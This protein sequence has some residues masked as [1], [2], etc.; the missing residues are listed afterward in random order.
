MTADA[1]HHVAG[2]D[3]T[4]PLPST[5]YSAPKTKP[6]GLDWSKHTAP[7]P[8]PAPVVE[9]PEATVTEIRRRIKAPRPTAGRKCQC[10]R[11]IN[12]KSDYCR[13]CNGRRAAANRTT[14]TTRTS[15]VDVTVAQEE[16]TA[17]A[18]VPEIAAAHDWPITSVRRQLERAG[19][20]MRDDRAGR[21]VGQKTYSDDLVEQV[22]ALYIDR[23]L[24]QAKVAAQLGLGPKVIV[25]L[26]ARHGIPARQG[27]SG[28]GDTLQAYRD[29]LDE[30]GVTAADVRQWANSH[31]HP[32]GIRGVVAEHVIDAYEDAHR[33]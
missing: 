29:R 15:V 10:G 8:H 28:G 33:G 5:R 23:G 17:G 19:V 32:C 2:G 11:D 25:T 26:M 21:T 22:R 24:S 4:R 13:S 27:Q 18:S 31:G 1:M 16:Y 14:F 6:R 30:L 7:E 20:T 3:W 12:T 9:Q